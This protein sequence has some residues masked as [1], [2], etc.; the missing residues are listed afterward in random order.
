MPRVRWGDCLDIGGPLGGTSARFQPIGRSAFSLT[1]CGQVMR[2]D[3]WP[4]LHEVR[5]PLLQ[6]LG[7]AAMQGLARATQQGAVGGVLDQR[8]LEQVLGDRGDTALE[9]EA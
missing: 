7:D 4:R 6:R 1:G 5:K 3:L 2:E 9:N 8:V